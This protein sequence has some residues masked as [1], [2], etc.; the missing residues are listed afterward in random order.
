MRLDLRFGTRPIFVAG[1]RAR[2]PDAHVMIVDDNSPDGT[3][4]IADAIAPAQWPRAA[5]APAPA[6]D[7]QP[8]DLWR[9]ADLPADYFP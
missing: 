9:I 7:Q 4:A 8:V 2:L 6:P 1:V 5:E 3:G